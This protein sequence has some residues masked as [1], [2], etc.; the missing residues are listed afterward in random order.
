MVQ[1]WAAIAQ[2][3]LVRLGYIKQDR[4]EMSYLLYLTLRDGGETRAV[5]HQTADYMCRHN[6]E[7]GFEV[8]WYYKVSRSKAYTCLWQ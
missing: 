5:T 4:K 6:L 8:A 1:P 7:Y 2:I 3:T